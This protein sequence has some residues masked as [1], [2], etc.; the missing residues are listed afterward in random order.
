VL[1]ISRAV[2]QTGSAFPLEG[3][4]KFQS[5]AN[6]KSFEI[7]NIDVQPAVCFIGKALF[8]NSSFT[9]NATAKSVLSSIEERN[10]NEKRDV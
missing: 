10:E 1:R 4:P 9:Q 8:E 5:P 2:S 3:L 7:I 6:V